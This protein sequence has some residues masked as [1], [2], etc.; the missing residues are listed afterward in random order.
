MKKK[1]NKKARDIWPLLTITT[2]VTDTHTNGQGDSMTDPA[3]RAKSVKMD[4]LFSN[5]SD[6]MSTALTVAVFDGRG[7]LK[8]YFHTD[9][10]SARLNRPRCRFSEKHHSTM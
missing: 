3:H 9:I 4:S 5:I 1:K 10:A 6:Q 8:K 7:I 2:F